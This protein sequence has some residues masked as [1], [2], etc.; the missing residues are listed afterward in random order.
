MP[1]LL[2]SKFLLQ[3]K[4]GQ[5]KN[6]PRTVCCQQVKFQYTLNICGFYFLPVLNKWV[7]IIGLV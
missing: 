3:Q 6:L 2:P 1:C 7:Q 4:V 5:V